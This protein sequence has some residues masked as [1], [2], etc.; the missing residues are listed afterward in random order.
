MVDSLRPD[1]DQLLPQRGQRPVLHRPR[2]REPPQ[3]VPEVVR[4]GEELKPRLVVPE[5]AAVS[6]KSRASKH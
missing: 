5:V 6:I 2:Q 1:L 3:E 4:Q